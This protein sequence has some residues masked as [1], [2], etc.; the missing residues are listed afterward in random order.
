MTKK[1]AIKW[2]L[3]LVISA[4]SIAFLINTNEIDYDVFFVVSISVTVLFLII[5]G[6]INAKKS[7]EDD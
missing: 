1:I 4:I 6:Y 7:F 3:F 2:I 5:F